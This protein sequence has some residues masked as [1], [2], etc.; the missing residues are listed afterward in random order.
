MTIINEVIRIFNET[1][2]DGSERR[3]QSIK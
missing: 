1:E 2:I 3:S